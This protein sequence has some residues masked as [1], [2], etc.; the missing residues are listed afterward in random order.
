MWYKGAAREGGAGGRTGEGPGGGSRGERS[1]GWT[2]NS[3]NWT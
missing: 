3:A 2:W 1:A